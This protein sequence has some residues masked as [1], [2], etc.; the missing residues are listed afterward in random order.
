MAEG[1]A[2][3]ISKKIDALYG[4]LK[5]IRAKLDALEEMMSEEEASEDDKKALSEALEEHREGK[6]IS[7]D[8]ALRKL[9]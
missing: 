5:L 2:V 4:E 1:A 8:E 9:K 3:D 6:T 7:L